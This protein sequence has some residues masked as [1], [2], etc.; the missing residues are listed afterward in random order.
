MG[1]HD[2][3]Y[4]DIDLFCRY[5][6]CDMADLDL[7]IIAPTLYIG[8]KF[9]LHELVNACETF[10]TNNICDETACEFL[11]YAS[12]YKLEELSEVSLR[13]I[14]ENGTACM[15][16]DGFSNLSPES[17]GKV[18]CRDSLGVMEEDV[19]DAVMHWAYRTCRKRGLFATGV[20]CRE[21]IGDNLY[22]LRI[23][24][25]DPNIFTNKVVETEI[26]SDLEKVDMFRY[27]Y[28]NP[29]NM[30]KIRF[31]GQARRKIKLE[32]AESLHSLRPFPSYPSLLSSTYFE[33]FTQ[34]L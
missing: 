3:I 14:D 18:I 19:F 33:N 13:Y 22:L 26:L 30:P 20:N 16:S 4:T 25:I 11:E 10:L 27:F 2:V 15:K 29:T 12:T 8:Q 31:P 6:Y 21:V 34:T 5:V 17:L 9:K 1:F 7:E 32:S 23:P 28:G 24:L